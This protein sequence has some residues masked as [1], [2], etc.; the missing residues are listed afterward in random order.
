MTNS[1]P[2]F[3]R[4]ATKP[5]WIGALAIALAAAA[6]FASFGQW[7]L[8]RSIRVVD[9]PQDIDVVT[10]LTDIT[11]H[12]EPFKT[13]QIDRR[14]SAT[15][16]LNLGT[17][18]VVENRVQLNADGS[19]SK[20]FWVMS[21][22]EDTLGA[23]LILAHGFTP[24]RDSAIR[25]CKGD[26][27]HLSAYIVQP[28]FEMIIGRYEPTEEIKQQLGGG[29]GASAEQKKIYGAT[30]A[31]ESVS[32][33]QVINVLS[34]APVSVYAGYVIMDSSGYSALLEP[35]KIGVKKS[36]SQLNLLSVFYFVE[37]MLFAGFAVFLWFRL[38]QDERDRLAALD[39][40]K[41]EKAKG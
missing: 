26:S 32:I 9:T 31:F 21:D 15:V 22:S 23:H 1:R 14:V 40:E 16:R 12:G 41:P 8:E 19:T 3:L 30:R 20:G 25:V 17:C 29:D 7:Q 18:F 33:P 13:N 5:K 2:G 38:V 35:I 6:L 11:A 24:N 27:M 10:P 36:D 37:W 28:K 34:E 39:G 4:V